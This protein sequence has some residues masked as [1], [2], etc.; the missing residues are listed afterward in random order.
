MYVTWWHQARSR[1]PWPL[2]AGPNHAEMGAAWWIPLSRGSSSSNPA[3]LIRSRL[4]V[5]HG[6]ALGTPL[7]TRPSLL[8]MGF[9]SCYPSVVRPLKSLLVSELGQQT[10]RQKSPP[11]GCLVQRVIQLPQ[12]PARRGGR[13]LEIA[14]SD[15]GAIR[16][17]QNESAETVAAH[18]GRSVLIVGLMALPAS[19]A[20]GGGV[21]VPLRLLRRPSGRHPID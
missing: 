2:S 8:G 10:P 3:S 9:E 14:R 18:L 20:G 17:A 6:R 16:A 11:V 19:L 5:R 7:H 13:Q 15:G 1:H 21:S 12:S 4:P